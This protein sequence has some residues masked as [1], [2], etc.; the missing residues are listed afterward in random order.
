MNGRCENVSQEAS[1]V[2][3]FR[4]EF[5]AQNWGQHWIGGW[6]SVRKKKK[7]CF[8]NFESQI[9]KKLLHLSKDDKKWVSKEA[10]SNKNY[11]NSKSLYYSKV[12]HSPIHRMMCD[13]IEF[14]QELGVFWF[15]LLWQCWKPFVICGTFRRFK[16]TNWHDNC[17]QRKGMYCQW[18]LDAREREPSGDLGW[19]KNIFLCLMLRPPSYLW[20]ASPFVRTK[21][22]DVCLSASGLG[23]QAVFWVFHVSKCSWLFAFSVLELAEWPDY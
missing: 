13:G 4:C 2:Y 16:S 1:K 19:R 7:K 23:T 9:E 8:K 15:G 10:G 12:C 3:A 22:V 14:R 18:I 21:T 20:L 6:K 11:S 5:L 17:F